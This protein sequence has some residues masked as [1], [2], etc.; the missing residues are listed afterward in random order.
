[1]AAISALLTCLVLQKKELQAIFTE[2][3]DSFNNP[4]E[5]V[6]LMAF[7]A[8][9]RVVMDCKSKDKCGVEFVNIA[10]VST[11]LGWCKA[12][13]RLMGVVNAVK[14]LRD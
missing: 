7:G 8:I 9:A 3:F 2:I 4:S 14:V 5:K 10:R 1:M 13:S 11:L 12:Q 6:I